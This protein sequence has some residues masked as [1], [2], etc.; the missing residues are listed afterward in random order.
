MVSF[1]SSAV[2][3]EPVGSGFW[4]L[5]VQGAL[6]FLSEHTLEDNYF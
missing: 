5:G 2:V 6:V 4:V 1:I 3:E